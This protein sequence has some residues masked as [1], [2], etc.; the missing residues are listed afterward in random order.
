MSAPAGPN[1]F[2]LCPRCRRSHADEGAQ[3]RL[4]CPECGYVWEPPL[5]DLRDAYRVPLEELTLRL[6]SADGESFEVRELPCILGRDSDFL[7]LQRNAS[8]SRRHC[9][10]KLDETHRK[11]LITPLEQH[12]R[13][14]LNGELLMS[15]ETRELRLT[16][17]IDLAGVHIDLELG[18]KEAAPLAAA[19][20]GH[21]ELTLDKHQMCYVVG[22][23]RGGLHVSAA[24]GANA[25][26]LLW[27]AARTGSW[28]A[29]ALNR[30]E[31]RIDGE[32]FVERDL[33]GGE[34]LQ[35]NG[36][37]YSFA[38]ERG[39]LVPSE[40]EKGA[41][42]AVDHVKAGYGKQV[43]LR[44]VC[45]TIPA[46]RLTAIVGQSGCGKSTL[47][48]VL[49]GQKLPLQG[50]VT[51][52]DAMHHPEVEHAEA[53]IDWARENQALVPQFSVAH[54]ELTVRQSVE[55]AADLRLK[56]HPAP[57]M[58]KDAMTRRALKETGLE[59]LADA[60]V[61]E[62]SGGQNK[63]ANIAMEIVGNPKFLILDEPTTGLDYA[64]E[65]RV[66]ACMRQMSR[67]GR[68]LLFVTHSLAA[69]EAVDHV[70][71][72]H[73]EGGGT[74]VA[75][76]G[77]PA[78]V[79]HAMGVDSWE[80]LFLQLE[81]ETGK[82]MPCASVEKEASIAGGA[83]R[84]LLARL[85]A[86]P[87]E[88]RRQPA[89]LLSLLA[90]YVCQ[91][92]NTLR[93]STLLLFGLPILLGGMITAA[94]ADEPMD[95]ILFA[96]VAMFWL[97]MNQSVREIVKE[98]SIF[99]H[100]HSQSVSCFAY[101][102]ARY[103]FFGLLTLVQSILLYIPLCLN[104][105][106]PNSNMLPELLHNCSFAHMIPMLWLGGLSGVVMGLFGSAAALFLRRQ[107]EVA[108]VLFA[109]ICTLPQIL[110]T[111]K[112][113]PFGLTPNDTQYYTFE[114]A[115][116]TAPLAEICSFFTSSRYLYLPLDAVEN[117]FSIAM[118]AF[119]F[120]LTL[121]L[122]VLACLVVL[123]HALLDWCAARARR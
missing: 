48:K 35:V 123:T 39:A 36:F 98:K 61:G 55:Y 78:D 114:L 111:E 94:A 47:I 71:V 73:R 41:G 1:L 44:D 10:I 16:D 106:G 17:Y 42:I 87:K 74:V 7:A 91:W 54:D 2:V 69:L 102:G 105:N 52:Q 90:R 20:P 25:S 8:V 96:L 97:G 31:L 122:G 15:G 93:T 38:A 85:C 33:Q 104:F 58:E 27:Y 60:R 56:L 4:R 68:T 100:E 19:T 112:I 3:A 99:L 22:G 11:L 62:L 12:R 21:R 29:L 109:V 26:L 86:F 51:V 70:I 116:T 18:L 110:F 57:G 75:A 13:T 53:Y 30:Q 92:R 121:L 5:N 46:G 23:A 32:T 101:L 120:N 119:G 115:N 65:K 118:K 49:S 66:I 76:E 113:I 50:K 83:L 9:E 80:A 28:K 64:T 88:L 43:V 108:A 95:R 79:L 45:C 37:C 6:R 77:S 14:F 40:P 63:R 67:R 117:K 34:L 84:L 72:L 103:I 82:Q 59:A 107:G 81:A 24:R 89:A